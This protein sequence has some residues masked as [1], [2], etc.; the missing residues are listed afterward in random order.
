MKPQSGADL[1]RRVYL[2]PVVSQWF[3]ASGMEL[4]VLSEEAEIELIGHC[5]TCTKN[6]AFELGLSQGEDLIGRLE[7]GNLN[8]RVKV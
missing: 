8:G 4:R 5:I 2:E 1:N 3:V 6:Q 7:T